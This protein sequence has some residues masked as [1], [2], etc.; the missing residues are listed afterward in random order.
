MDKET[1][2]KNNITLKEAIDIVHDFGEHLKKSEEGFKT[3]PF[4]YESTL[5]HEKSLIM[6][7][8]T[9][10]LLNDDTKVARQMKKTIAEVKYY[11]ELL[12][13][14]CQFLIT[15]IPDIDNY[16]KMIKANKNIGKYYKSK[17]FNF[18]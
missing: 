15:Y 1:A 11:K 7:A 14:I 10:I 4:Q 6:L 18:K 3:G 16:N 13:G 2:Q 17:S 8:I 5:P 12:S 9:T